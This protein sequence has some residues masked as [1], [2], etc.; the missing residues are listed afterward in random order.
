[1]KRKK[2]NNLVDKLSRG[3]KS[4]AEHE[5]GPTAVTERGGAGDTP[6]REERGGRGS[7]VTQQ[8]IMSSAMWGSQL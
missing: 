8:I 7:K 5:E 2:F 4:H 3:D 1:M 6:E